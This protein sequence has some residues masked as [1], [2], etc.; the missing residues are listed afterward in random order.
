M[1]SCEQVCAKTPT[2]YLFAVAKLLYLLVHT[3]TPKLVSKV[4]FLKYFMRE[5]EVGNDMHKKFTRQTLTLQFTVSVLTT[6]PPGSTSLVL[7]N[8]PQSCLK[9]SMEVSKKKCGLKTECIEAF[10]VT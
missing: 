2:S 8:N 3:H 6:R 10:K 4:Q 7:L 1:G 9:T 5:R